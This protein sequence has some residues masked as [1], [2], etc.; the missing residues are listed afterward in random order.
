MTIDA[1]AFRP[2][3]L[4]SA[5]GSAAPAA[6]GA[7]RLSRCICE[8]RLA[9]GPMADDR[10]IIRAAGPSLWHEVLQQSDRVRKATITNIGTILRLM[11]NPLELASCNWLKL[12]TRPHCAQL[13]RCGLDCY[14]RSRTRDRTTSVLLS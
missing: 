1:A 2:I 9:R 11:V 14:L 3:C 6:S 13:D 4:I 7:V 10:G 5:G 8:C 12:T